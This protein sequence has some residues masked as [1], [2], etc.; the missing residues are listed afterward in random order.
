MQHVWLKG[1]V[2][3]G[4]WWG[5]LRERLYIEDTG[6]DGKITFRK[7]DVGVLTRQ[8]CLKIWTESGT[9]ECV[10]EPSGSIKCAE[11]LD[12]LRVGLLLKKDSA[13]WST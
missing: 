4:F 5:N 2:Y 7:W 12:Y 6:A 9:C 13:P 10:N 8:I 1:E 11:F 3:K